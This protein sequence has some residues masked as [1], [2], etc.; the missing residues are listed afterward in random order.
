KREHREEEQDDGAGG[1]A[2]RPARGPE[3]RERGRRPTD[4][5]REERDRR[6]VEPVLRDERV[7][8]MVDVE[9]EA[10]VAERR[11]DGDDEEHDRSSGEEGP[12]AVRRGA[13]H[14]AAL[15]DPSDADNAAGDLRASSADPP[16]GTPPAVRP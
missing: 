11:V 14:R 9:D 15:P 13:G 10:R 8:E 4:G 3:A 16:G 2:D 7:A 6:G 1:S 12:D 5:E